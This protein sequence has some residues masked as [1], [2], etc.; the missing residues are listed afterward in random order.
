MGSEEAQE[1]VNQVGNFMNQAKSW[2]GWV[3]L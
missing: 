1:M 3:P 2:W